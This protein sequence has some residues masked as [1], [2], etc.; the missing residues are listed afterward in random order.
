MEDP[1]ARHPPERHASSS[2]GSGSNG[3]PTKRVFRYSSMAELPYSHNQDQYATSTKGS[4]YDDGSTPTTGDLTPMFWS[5]QPARPSN[6][7]RESFERRPSGLAPPLDADDDISTL[8]SLSPFDSNVPTRR[9][10]GRSSA[11]SVA[12]S[13]SSLSC[14]IPAIRYSPHAATESLRSPVTRDDDEDRLTSWAPAGLR[15]GVRGNDTVTDFPITA[16][17]LMS[18]PAGRPQPRSS[19]AGRSTASRI[20]GVQSRLSPQQSRSSRVRRASQDRSQATDETTIV[21]DVED[22]FETSNAIFNKNDRNERRSDSGVEEGSAYACSEAPSLEPGEENSSSHDER[23][24]VARSES[25]SIKFFR[26]MVTVVLLCGALSASMGVYFYFQS[27][28]TSSF[29][30][31]FESDT[32]H[33]L[34]SIGVSMK[35]TLE[36]ADGFVSDILSQTPSSAWPLV[37]I[38]NFPRKAR[39]MIEL[40]KVR[41][42]DFNIVVKPELRT[43][44]ESYASE[45]M[46]WIHGSLVAQAI[47]RNE[48]IDSEFNATEYSGSYWIW[49]ENDNA[50]A[51]KPFFLPLWQHEPV[52]EQIDLP[53]EE[54]RVYNEDAWQSVDSVA[55]ND[56]VTI[57][58]QRR[59][60]IGHFKTDIDIDDGDPFS[61]ISYPI[62][63]GG[64]ASAAAS[65]TKVD[66]SRPV[67]GSVRLSLHWRDVLRDILPPLSRNIEVVL[68]DSCTGNSHTYRID[69]PNVVDIGDGDLHESKTEF[70]DMAVS[71]TVFDLIMASDDE[72]NGYGAYE[73]LPIL[74]DCSHVLTFYPNGANKNEFTTLNA[75]YFS[76]LSVLIFL[77]VFT[78][79]LFYDTLVIKRQRA[80]VRHVDLLTGIVSN[81]FPSAIREQLYEDKEENNKFNARNSDGVVIKAILKGDGDADL[82]EL[83]EPSYSGEDDVTV[84]FHN[85]KPMAD[86]FQETTVMYVT[87]VY[88]K[89][90][91]PCSGQVSHVSFTSFLLHS[92]GLPT[93]LDLRDGVPL[94]ALL[95]CSSSLRRFTVPSIPLQR[96]ARS[97]KLKQSAIATSQVR[98]E[99]ALFHFCSYISYLFCVLPSNLSPRNNFQLLVSRHRSV[100]SFPS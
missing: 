8:A 61:T 48:S 56:L 6:L 7:S 73:G 87:N 19:P 96:D 64:V 80:V 50:L 59:V 55:V 68:S 51:I 20:S 23:G 95:K 26:I 17:P 30:R 34:Q 93:L 45:N 3:T 39:R 100:A 66:T 18:S 49:G 99:P 54:R 28:E 65:S 53:I 31:A 21:V 13:V 41:S 75:L 92:P 67:V 15:H 97:S 57:F 70:N 60:V 29:E 24:K 40:T 33:L 14:S 37:T 44:W 62:I 86:L 58:D 76:V 43:Q 94:A 71:S 36:A 89:D 74:N 72:I 47:D 63:A 77:F 4:H 98:H 16:P 2:Q 83:V 32:N 42:V 88:Y 78:V 84:G 52:D 9:I 22:S 91:S 27:T 12:T 11:I 46:R 10:M 1:I 85:T 69:G 82:D 5:P 25:D 81:L 90:S 35:H 79:F 38:P